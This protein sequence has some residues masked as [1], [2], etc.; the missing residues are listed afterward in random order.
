MVQ[1][2]TAVR[3]RTAHELE[4]AH[5][6]EQIRIIRRQQGQEHQ[7]LPSARNIQNHP[8]TKTP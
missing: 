2:S 1:D 6:E 7:L 8:L 4:Q 3:R 5:K